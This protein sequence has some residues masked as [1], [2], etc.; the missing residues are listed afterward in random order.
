MTS[1]ETPRL[2]PS[3]VGVS[4][5]AERTPGMARTSSSAAAGRPA[6][7][8]V[9]ASSPA[10]PAC[11]SWVTAWSMVV[12]LNSSVQLMPTVSISGVLADE[13]RRVAVRRFADARKPPTGE[14]RASGGPRTPAARRATIGPRKPTAATR[15]SA[16]ISDVAAAVSGALVVA[17]T[18][19]SGAAPASAS[20]PPITRPGPSSRGS[21]AASASAR[22]GDTRAA[23]RPAART[24]SSAA[25]TPP[26]TAAAI[27][28]QPALTVRFGGAMPWLTSPSASSRP[29]I[30]PGQIPAAEPTRP[31]IAA[32]HAIMRRI[33]PGV[34][35][36]ARRSAISRSR[37]WIDR[38]I[39]LATTKI[40][41]NSARPPNDAV[42]AISVVRAAWSSG[43]SALPRASPVSTT[44]P[45]AAARRREASKPGPASTPIASTRPG[46]SRPAAP[47]RR[48]SGRSPSAAGPGGGGERRRPR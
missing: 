1:S 31:T 10:R 3:V 18:A 28:S 21:T 19:N 34:A 12:A 44:A 13:K 27:G 14:S 2:G 5:T 6:P 43:Y 4:A 41:M 8:L 33:W 15:K 46:M 22:V 45:S 25:T 48:R 40:A 37:C 47:P 9:T 39:V 20:S 11:R 29:R 35:A 30:A 38:P 42:T 36:T 24:A 23:R 32:S 26:P 16:V 7:L 17:E